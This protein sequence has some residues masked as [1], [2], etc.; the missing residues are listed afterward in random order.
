MIYSLL[1][2][3]KSLSPLQNGKVPNPPW[4]YIYES[5]QL[6]WFKGSIAYP[7]GFLDIWGQEGCLGRV[8]HLAGGRCV[9]CDLQRVRMKWAGDSCPFPMVPLLAPGWLLSHVLLSGS[10]GHLRVE[11]SFPFQLEAFHLTV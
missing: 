2:E 9:F 4:Q 11:P 6:K 1:Q 7:S 8:P 3:N 5:V 10:F